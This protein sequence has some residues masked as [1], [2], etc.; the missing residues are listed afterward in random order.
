M[1]LITHYVLRNMS[2]HRARSIGVF[3]AYLVIMVF[4]AAELSM[5]DDFRISNETALDG[6]FGTH[7]GIFCSETPNVEQYGDF[8]KTGV[9]AVA[10][11]ETKD[12]ESTGRLII[13][14]NAD[15]TAV[16][17]CSITA[18]EGRLPKTE[19]E[20]ALERSLHD[21]LFPNS[22]VGDNIS[23]NINSSEKSQTVYLL[24]GIVNDF[25]GYQWDSSGNK[26]EMPNA[27]VGGKCVDAMYYF[28][29]VKGNVTVTDRAIFLPNQRNSLDVM[30]SMFGI[31]SDDSTA[32]LSVVLIMF[33]LISFVAV[34]FVF[35]RMNDRF[36]I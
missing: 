36:I 1:K 34:L 9:M 23:I 2:L 4:F 19:N 18:V 24:C 31:S 16:S 15:D 10:F 14:G 32:I 12:S 33:V 26:P 35:S 28:V 11:N 29:S 7:D 13:A 8:E 27:L 21:I 30:N 3:L 22:A 5:L 17:L 20:I 6:I 25:S